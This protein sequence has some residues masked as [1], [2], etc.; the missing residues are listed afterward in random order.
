MELELLE[1][2]AMEPLR[3]EFKRL[4]ERLLPETAGLVDA[5]DHDDFVLNSEL[6]RADGRAYAGL[7][8]RKSTHADNFDANA[9]KVKMPK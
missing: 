5:F 2:S 4:L 9:T 7:W 8:S 1:P 3:S 6:G